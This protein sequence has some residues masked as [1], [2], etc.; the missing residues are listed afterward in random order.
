MEDLQA[1]TQLGESLTTIVVVLALLFAERRAHDA[2][3]TTLED[4]RREHLAD[5]RALANSRPYI[6]M[7]PV[8]PRRWPDG[9]V[10]VQPPS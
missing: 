7:E 6:N 5:L 3:R 1:L 8:A 10:T 9:V 2:T 4:A